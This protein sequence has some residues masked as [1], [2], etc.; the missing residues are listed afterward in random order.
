MIERKTTF[1]NY[2]NIYYFA[3]LSLEFYGKSKIKLKD[4]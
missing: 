4:Y 3:M 2:K 1:E